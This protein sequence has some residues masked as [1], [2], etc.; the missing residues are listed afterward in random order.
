ME[1]LAQGKS[2]S[3]V[4]GELIIAEGTAKAHTRHIYEKL[5]I[6]TR[7]ELLDLLM[8]EQ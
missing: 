1:L 5:G 4:A 3:G 8:A 7:Q 2:L 6:N